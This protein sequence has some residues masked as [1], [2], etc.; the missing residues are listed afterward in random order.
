MA[1]LGT[2]VGELVNIVYTLLSDSLHDHIGLMKMVFKMKMPNLATYIFEIY[3]SIAFQRG[4]ARAHRF[5]NG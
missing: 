5:A 2:V 1:T 4:I 3:R